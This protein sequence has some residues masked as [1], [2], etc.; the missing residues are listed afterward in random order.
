MHTT[1]DTGRVKHA[2]HYCLLPVLSVSV[3]SCTLSFE[4][5]AAVTETS[6]CYDNSNGYNDPK[7]HMWNSAP[8]GAI[9]NTNWPGQDMTQEGSFYCYDPGVAVNSLNVI[10]N[11]NGNPQ[12]ADLNMP[13][14]T[15][16]Y[17]NNQ[18]QTLADCGLISVN[19]PPVANAGADVTVNLGDSV[20]LDGSN[21]SDADGNIVSYQWDNG[22]TGVSP[23]TTFNSEGTFTITLTVTDDQGATA[24]DSVV[25]TVIDTSNA[26]TVTASTIC[27]DNAA[28]F[29]NPTVYLWNGQPQGAFANLDWPGEALTATGNVYCYD[30][31]ADLTSINVIFND[32]GANQTAD[33]AATW[34]NVCYQNNQWTTLQSCGL[35]VGTGPDPV[36]NYPQGKAIYYINTNNFAAPTVHTWDFVPAA[37][38]PNSDWPGHAMAEFGGFNA[39][40]LDIPEDITSGKVIFTDN[41]ANQTADLDFTG[42]NLCYNNGVWMTAT[43]CGIPTQASA[44]AGPDRKANQNSQIALT[45]VAGNGDLAATTWQSDAWSGSLMGESVVTPELT[46]QGTYTVTMTLASGETDTFALE[47]VAAT[48]ALPERPQLLKP[49]NFP[50]SGSV[51]SGNYT[52]ESAFPALDGYF[53]SPVHVTNDGVNDLIYVVDKKGTLSVFANDP[54][55]TQAQVTTLLDITGEVRNYHEQGLLSVAFHP[56]FATNGYAYIFYIEGDNDNESDNGVFGDAVL[57]RITLNDTTL[58]TAASDR[59][60]ILRIPQPGPDHKGGMMQFH[61]STG[62]FFLSIGDGAYGD[63]AITPTQPDPRTNNSS[64][65]TDNLRGSFIRIIMRDTPNAQGLYYDIP[66]DNPFVNDPN[67]RDE[68]WSYGH[69]NPWRWAFDT[70][71]PYT[72]WETEI[73]QQGFEEVNIIQAGNNYG[74]PIC[75]G[76]T[77]RGNDGGDANFSRD[78][79]NDLTGPIGGYDHNTGSVSIIGGFVYRGSQLPGL[80]GRFIYG[81]YVS[82]KIWSATEGDT[83]VLV[84]DAFPS[85]IS[86]FG[87]DVSGEEV[88]ISSHGE[89]YGGL[90]SIYRMVDSDVQAAVIPATLSATGLFADL[91]TLTPVHGVIEYDVNS[92]GWFD[93]LIT[94]HFIALPNG[95]TI[96]FDANNVWD[97]PAGSVLVKHLDRPINATD[98]VPYQTSVLFRQNSGN[99]AAANYYWNAQATDADLVNQA[100]E[101]TVE[102]FYD[103]APS[104]VQ[105]RVR[106]GAECSSCHTGTGSKEPISIDTKQLNKDFD[107]QGVVANQLDSFNQVGIFDQNIGFAANLAELPDP[108]DT[109]RSVDERARAYLDTNCSHCHGGGF[110]DMNYETDLKDMEIMNIKRGAVYR[111]LPFDHS[112]SIIYNYQTDDANRMPKG[113]LITNPLASTLIADWIDGVGASQTAMQVTATNSSVGIGASTSVS[114]MALYDNG[115][116][117]VPTAGVTWSSSDTSVVTV[118]GT[119]GQATVQGV[120]SGSATITASSGGYSGNIVITVAT[121]PDAPT[122]LTAVAASDTSISLS[123]TD[124]ATDEVNYQVSRST[125]AAGPFTVISTLAANSTSM[126]DSGLAPST[127]YYYQVVAKGASVDSA[128]ASASAQTQDPAPIDGLTIVAPATVQLISGESRQLVAVATA[129]DETVSATLSSSWTSANSNIVSVS[130]SGLLSAGSTAGVTTITVTNQG[131]ST[132]IQVENLGVAQ[133]IYFNTPANWA[134]PTAYIWTDEN[135]ALTTRSAAWPGSAV[136]Q[137]ADNLGGTW[138]K[139]LIPVNWANSNGDINIIFNNAGANQT[140]DLT[141]NIANP[142]YY[143]QG[144]LAQAPTGDGSEAGTQIQIGNGVIT[145]SGSA[146]LTGKLF[147]VGTVLDV[148]ADPAGT[149]LEFKQWE[150]SGAAYLVDAKAENTQIVV[151][152]ALSFTLLAVFGPATDDHLVGRSYYNDQGCAGCHG[153]DGTG[154]PSLLGLSSQYTLAELTSYIETNMPIGNASL[155]TGECASSTAA[156]ILDEAF[157]APSNTCNLDDL[158]DVVPQDRSYRLLS[159]LEYN[160]SVRD[161]LGLTTDIDVTSGNVPA[162]IPANGF[163]TNANTVFTNDYAKGYVLAAEAA[164]SMVADMYSLTSGCNNISCFLD[165]FAKRAFRRPLTATEK[166]S[167]TGVYNDQGQLALLSTILSSPAMLYRSEVGEVNTD[168][169]FEL[170]DYE[171][172]TLLAYTYWATTPDSW[173]MSKAD[174]GELSTSTQIASTL[175]IMLQ[176]AKAEIAFERFIAGWLNLDREIK[177]SDLSASLK[178]DMRQ[179]TIE[180]VKRIVFGGGEYSE[181]L[182]AKYSYMTEQLAT[183]Y[184]FT[185]PG[186][187]GWQR[188]D[189]DPAESNGE[190]AGVMG[191]AGILA[192]QSA[193]EKT[194]PVKR[195]LFVRKNLMCQDFP[196]PP[197][198][199]ELKPQEDPTLTVR[200]R[201]EHAHLQDGCESCHQFIDGIGFGLENFNAYGQYVTTE[202]TD[203]GEIKPINAAGYIGSLTSAETFLSASEPVVNY[204]GMDELAQ[205]VVDSDHGKSCYA[206]QWFRYS[207]GLHEDSNDNCTLQAY[208]D[209]F[210]SSSSANLLDLMVEFTQTKNFTLRK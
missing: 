198:G 128:A 102:Q 101:E 106:S 127:L 163:K 175:A 77:H 202:T 191:H 116:E 183:H 99:W 144:W 120:N 154:S 90:S 49:L 57:E 13:G 201:F 71:L 82:K 121:G 31:E 185:W 54:N 104:L 139:V 39:W 194:H 141:V 2:L 108:T 109:S 147:P 30:T 44:D 176:D 22:S 177:T 97:L 129:G 137:T 200:E 205:L 174:N 70:V 63:T 170:T 73:G 79:T 16:C 23:T 122:D 193:S 167:L 100:F 159:T 206:R 132:N 55:V 11:D 179:E 47:V 187:T 148:T 210:K 114:A 74:W 33:L 130:N 143:D 36:Y 14:A 115:F 24:T 189:Y 178:A 10:F 162:D 69:R 81:D 145:L 155:C 15:T 62:E 87:T 208:G 32:N 3:M 105:H 84:S 118:S 83:D 151:A 92:D 41:G 20:I 52:Y 35:N 98:S 192:I 56:N 94:R 80:T 42:D 126:T 119:T 196:P 78:C 172:A 166:T 9:V 6:I 146:D 186:G 165:D 125:A 149:G 150:G 91:T 28:N 75:E 66:A 169:Y 140:A 72:L 131:I 17:Q 65:E 142:S 21:S 18:W 180:F 95:E 153:A 46:V 89:E 136:T 76:N 157:T 1:K 181:L 61:P 199:A 48:Q 58:P 203:A 190:R 124:V 96:N 85:N 59:V 51:S 38:W 60:E 171:V 188:V 135:G 168:G 103:Q 26:P 158:D 5:Q 27:Y 107:Y 111:M 207:R 34:P 19:Q 195:G 209:N 184:G 86:S 110:M 53:A 40:H 64:Q 112:A 50:L 134:N 113:S 152:D 67:V 160:N 161:L 7:I 117:V 68:I 138:H 182:T 45:V 204:Q 25:V 173:L 197:I 164:A 4:T 29:T 43:A 37:S 88:F 12:T 93:G 133:Y 8:A 156:M 123:W